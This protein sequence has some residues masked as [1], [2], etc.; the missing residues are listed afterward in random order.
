MLAVIDEA[1]T[2]TGRASGVVLLG[3]LAGLGIGPPI[4][5]ATVDATDSYTTMWL[6]SIAASAVAL[7]LV[8]AWR[9]SVGSRG[10]LA[11][12]G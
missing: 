12:G 3:F 2:A 1:G 7:G 5:G 4:F 11:I 6:L 10:G 9:R 8:M